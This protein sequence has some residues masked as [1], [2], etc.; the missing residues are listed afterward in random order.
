MYAQALLLTYL[1]ESECCLF[2]L[3][4][5]HDSI[6]QLACNIL[7]ASDAHI[8]VGGSLVEAL[9][10]IIIYDELPLLIE[11]KGS[12][13]WREPQSMS[14]HANHGCVTEFHWTSHKPQ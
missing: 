1:K 7:T 6:H 8:P 13:V 5:S 3:C 14:H 11:P 4:L 9:L 2:L 10:V 12:S